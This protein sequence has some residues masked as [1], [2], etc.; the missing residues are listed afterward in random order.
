MIRKLI[1]TV[2]LCSAGR[3]ALAPAP[4]VTE[5]E[6]GESRDRE[7]GRD[8]AWSNLNGSSGSFS[9]ALAA[10]RVRSQRR[11]IVNPGDVQAAL[12]RRRA[13]AAT[14]PFAS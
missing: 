8:D 14:F 10:A 3:V 5:P 9:G 6:K 4:S 2:S 12:A 1:V 11:A 7:T 13:I